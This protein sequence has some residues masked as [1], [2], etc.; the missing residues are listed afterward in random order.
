MGYKTTRRQM[1]VKGCMEWLKAHVDYA[2]DDCLIWP[3]SKNTVNGYGQIGS[4]ASGKANAAHR[5]M[6]ELAH[7]PKPS[8]KHQAAHSCHTR[9][10]VNPRHLAWKTHS[11]N[12][13]DKRENGTANVNYWGQKGKLKV[14]QAAAIL[15]LKG[16]DT[17]RAIAERFG[18]T[19]SQVRNIHSGKSWSARIAE[20]RAS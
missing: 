1:R 17:Q 5:I 10:C 15:D 9:A 8:S 19:E 14:E 7:G 20:Y 12:M 6:C 18:I 11:Q 2:G 4:D 13:L 16:R 3:W